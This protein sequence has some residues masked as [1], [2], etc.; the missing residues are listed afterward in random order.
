M[1]QCKGCKHYRSI[2]SVASKRLYAC[3]YIL[4]TEHT[5]GVVKNGKIVYPARCKNKCAGKYT[6]KAKSIT[7]KR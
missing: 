4:D 6:Y 5:R 3:N 1:N 7:A 2:G